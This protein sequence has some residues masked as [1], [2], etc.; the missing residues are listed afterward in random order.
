MKFGF[1]EFMFEDTWQ[2]EALEDISSA[3]EVNLVAVIERQAR[4]LYLRHQYRID[5][6]LY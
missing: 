2:K 4:L 3:Y 1:G 6:V 5:I